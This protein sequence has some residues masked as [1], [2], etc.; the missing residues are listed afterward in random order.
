MF[1]KEFLRSPLET[2]VVQRDPRGFLHDSTVLYC[3]MVFMIDYV[4][5]CLGGSKC[6][7]GMEAVFSFTHAPLKRKWSLN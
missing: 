7:L 1:R 4:R 3:E 5:S 6:I 2:R